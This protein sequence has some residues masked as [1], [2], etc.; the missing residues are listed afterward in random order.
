[1]K[2]WNT[3]P[4]DSIP[5][6]A[7]ALHLFFIQYSGWILLLY[8]RFVNQNL[9]FTGYE[10][11]RNLNQIEEGTILNLC[12]LDGSLRWQ[13][14][15]CQH[16]I[17]KAEVFPS[18]FDDTDNQS[19]EKESHGPFKCELI[20]LDLCFSAFWQYMTEVFG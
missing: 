5:Q 9:V 16:L 14:L 7:I 18:L 4:L 2:F 12:F 1:M 15:E 17:A 20:L 10:D 6:V 13:N 3:K 8:N 11:L 19:D